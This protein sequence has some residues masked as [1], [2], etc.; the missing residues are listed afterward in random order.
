MFLSKQSGTL[1]LFGNESCMDSV[2]CLMNTGH[3]IFKCRILLQSFHLS[4]LPLVFNCCFFFYKSL[5]SY[6]VV[7]YINFLKLFVKVHG[8]K[9]SIN[10][11]SRLYHQVIVI[12]LVVGVSIC[13]FCFR[14]V[15]SI[16]LC[17]NFVIRSALFGELLSSTQGFGSLD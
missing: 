15:W 8:V 7:T 6:Y 16:F 1:P 2:F 14:L 11:A 3:H 5:W 12:L 13:L 10:R 4:Y 17:S 9:I